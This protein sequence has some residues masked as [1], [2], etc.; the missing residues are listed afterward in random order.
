M[1]VPEKLKCKLLRPEK[2][3]KQIANVI[4]EVDGDGQTF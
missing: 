1:L 2:L 4:S 3:K